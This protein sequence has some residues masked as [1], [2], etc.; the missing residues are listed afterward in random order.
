MRFE[1]GFDED[2]NAL[3]GNDA[4]PYTPKQIYVL[5]KVIGSNEEKTKQFDA[6]MSAKNKKDM[7]I[8]VNS[9]VPKN[10]SFG[11]GLSS[12]PSSSTIQLVRD[13]AEESARRNQAHGVTFTEA[14]GMCAGDERILNLGAACLA[15]CHFRFPSCRRRVSLPIFGLGQ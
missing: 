5:K 9:L 1:L 2:G 4:S 15:E 3:P 6:L 8:F 12:A 14:L 7:R 11:W 13:R 10:A